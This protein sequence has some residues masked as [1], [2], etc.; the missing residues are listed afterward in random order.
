MDRRHLPNRV[1][2]DFSTGKLNRVWAA[3]LTYVR[4]AEGWLFLAVV[5]DVGSRRVVGWAMG[6]RADCDL[7]IRALDMAIV[8]RQPGPGLVHHSDRGVHYTSS[9]YRKLLEQHELLPSYS[10]L[11][12][13][14]DNAVVESFFHTLKTEEARR[15]YASRQ[16][17][18]HRLFDFIEVW[19]NR[20]RRH[21]ALGHLS[22]VEYEN[23]L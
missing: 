11:G 7:V 22:P 20:Q 16:E 13:C 6:G 17:A 15:F 10:A 21:S 9:R 19:Y 4:T 12:D 1:L 2:R 18:R 5:L 14:W 3:D 23:R 8:H